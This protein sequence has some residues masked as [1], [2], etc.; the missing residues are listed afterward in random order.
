MIAELIEQAKALLIFN[1]DS[2][3]FTV[4]EQDNTLIKEIDFPSLITAIQQTNFQ[5]DWYLNSLSLHKIC[6]QEGKIV[7]ISSTLP[8]SYLLEFKDFCLR[9]PLPGAVIVHCDSKLWLYAYQG[10]RDNL[11]LD[12]QLYKFPLPNISGT[13]QVCWGDVVLPKHCASAMW[14]CFVTSCFNQDYDDDKSLAHPHNIVTQLRQVS[15][16]L[17][18][19]YPEQDLVPTNLTL[20]NLAPIKRN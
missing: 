10:N 11:N 15:Q 12:S 18:V 9:V 20:A 6:Q 17:N 19:V 16:S 5:S 13:N 4:K 14:H 1:K 3:V 8:N 2:V 7:T